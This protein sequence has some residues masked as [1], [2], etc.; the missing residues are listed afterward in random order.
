MI[1]ETASATVAYDIAP[2]VPM[3]AP[4]IRFSWSVPVNPVVISIP[5]VR[6]TAR[7]IPKAIPI[8]MLC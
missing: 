2:P 4:V 1:R 6:K 8:I 5:D 7:L 3:T